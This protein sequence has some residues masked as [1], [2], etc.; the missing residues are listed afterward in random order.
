MPAKST[1]SQTKKS[2]LKANI[3]SELNKVKTP[4]KTIRKKTAKKTVKTSQVQTPLKKVVRKKVGKS[5]PKRV[6]ERALEEKVVSVIEQPED[7]KW[8]ELKKTE[9]TTQQR[10]TKPKIGFRLTWWHGLLT[11][12][13]L[14]GLALGANI[15][16]IYNW[17]WHG[18]ISQQV[19][20]YL[21]L[22]AGQVNGH[23]IKLSDYWSDLALLQAAVDQEREGAGVSLLPAEQLD[24]EKQIFNRLVMME[25]IK[26]ELNR[27]Q[28]E[29]TEDELDNRMNALL[30]QFGNP[31]D[32]KNAIADLYKLSLDEFKY[33]VLLPLLMQDKLQ[34]LIAQDAS[35]EINQSAKD[36]AQDILNIAMD[37]PADF[38]LI[39]GQF[40][41]DESGVN[42]GGDLG[43]INQGELSP[44]L[45]QII[46]S[47]P[48]HTVYDQVV[49]N[50]SGYHIFK[51]NQK[52]TDAETGKQA[53]KLAHILIRVDVTQHLKNLYQQAD[54][55]EYIPL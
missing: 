27:Y 33:K 54:I 39:A 16:G 30:A 11:A 41:Q 28:A 18:L 51:V 2:E 37:N 22:P 1:K 3:L 29:V 50:R 14:L 21:S 44:D 35:L 25:L 36:Q 20:K 34:E 32:A 49:P 8:E 23:K 52:L 10:V 12:L 43:W 7:V 13:I 5:K 40:T 24:M 45:E 38:S 46:F 19:A 6:P 53:V 4:T 48:N 55:K 26:D 17:Q 42:T 31:Q 15:Y 9:Y 47:L